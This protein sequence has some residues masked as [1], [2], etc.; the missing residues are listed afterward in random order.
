MILI[1]VLFER[2]VRRPIQ[3]LLQS[4]FERRVYCPATPKPAT[5][6]EVDNDHRQSTPASTP[7]SG[8]LMVIDGP[9]DDAISMLTDDKEA[10]YDE[11]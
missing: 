5:K 10:R 7:N 6:A 11:S 4:R 8:T 3:I 1:H 2:R 9:A